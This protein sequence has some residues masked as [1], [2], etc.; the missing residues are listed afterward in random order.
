M[1]AGTFR[2]PCLEPLSK[3][4][5]SQ[6]HFCLVLLELLLNEVVFAEL[7]RR[8]RSNEQQMQKQRVEL[9][10][11]KENVTLVRDEIREQVQKYSSC[12]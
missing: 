1:T 6:L 12:V 8:F 9:D 7:E 11:L 5:N 10:G 4:P 3:V 2:E